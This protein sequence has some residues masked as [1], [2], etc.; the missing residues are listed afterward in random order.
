LDE[1][2]A[3]GLQLGAPNQVSITDN[4]LFTRE[5]VERLERIL[6]DFVEAWR[7]PASLSPQAYD[8]EK[9]ANDDSNQDQDDGNGRGHRYAVE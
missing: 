1:R 2:E 8:H 6:S 4:R 7:N 3:T 5:V 9:L